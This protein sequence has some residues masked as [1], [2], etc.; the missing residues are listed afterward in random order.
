MRPDTT[1]EKAPIIDLLYP[2]PE[3]REL[4]RKRRTKIGEQTDALVSDMMIDSLSKLI[5]NSN[6]YKMQQILTE[7]CDDEETI[8]YRLDIIDDLMNMPELAD[9]LGKIVRILID[10]DKGNIYG[11]LT[12]DSFTTLDSA[13]TAFE[14]YIRCIEF[15]HGF[16]ETKG[17]NANV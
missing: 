14:A 4:L 12:P 3:K 16:N 8:N 10:N 17:S 5:C 13:V 9:M 2:S 1:F 6:A 11:L 15:M 7:L